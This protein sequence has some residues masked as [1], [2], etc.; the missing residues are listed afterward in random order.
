VQLSFGFN[1]KIPEGCKVDYFNVIGAI[2]KVFFKKL[3]MKCDLKSAHPFPFDGNSPLLRKNEYCEIDN[4]I[5]EVILKWNKKE[6]SILD[7][8]FNLSNFLNYIYYFSGYVTVCMINLKGINITLLGGNF[9]DWMTQNSWID[10]LYIVNS[11][12]SFYIGKEKNRSCQDFY[13]NVSEINSIFQIKKYN[14]NIVV[15]LTNCKFREKICPL[16]FNNSK[17]EQL[18]I[19]NLANT[20]FKKNLLQFDKNSLFY[21]V[22]SNIYNLMLQNVQNIDLDTNLVNPSVFQS[23]RSIR[24]HGY[25]NSVSN[26]LFDQYFDLFHIEFQIA[27]VRKMFHKTGIEWIKT[28]NHNIDVN[29][30]NPGNLMVYRFKI[31][32]GCGEY[33]DE[34]ISKVFPNEDFCIYKNFPFNQLVFSFQ[35]CSEHRIKENKKLNSKLSCTYLWLTQYS[36]ILL[37]YLANNTDF[38]KSLMMVVESDSY[39]SILKCNFNQRL[40][41]CDK[42]NFQTKELWGLSDYVILNKI[43]QIVFKIST[44]LVFIFGIV[45][46]LIVIKVIMDKKNKEL[47]RKLS[48]IHFSCI[49]FGLQLAHIDYSNSF[50]DQRMLL[51]I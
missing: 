28:I 44:Y 41:L 46:N 51:S 49:K 38:Y 48:P 30:S 27:H 34:R 20:F 8:T 47:L 43:L 45:T 29:V 7:S 26:Y 24:V 3:S 33:Y 23:I 25:V 11:E 42:T 17:I 4:T 1:C 14:G 22:N 40:E 2:Y 12:M 19:N 37:Q 35:Y 31:T 21:E 50:M 39:K 32:Y 10:N 15:W 18:L 6:L 16:V 13:E 5:P 9:N 36:N